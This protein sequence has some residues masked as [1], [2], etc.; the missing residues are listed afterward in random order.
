MYKRQGDALEELRDDS[1][2][3]AARTIEQ[4]V[5]DPRQ[6]GGEMLIGFFFEDRKRRAQRKAKVGARVTVGN[7]EHVNVIQKILLADN[8]MDTGYQR[9]GERP[10]VEMAC[11]VIR[12][13]RAL[14]ARQQERPPLV[15]QHDALGRDLSDERTLFES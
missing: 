11:G 4:G 5:R 8:A 7:R 6:Q 10:A 14:F 9:L 15:L 1:P 13:T 3:V 2:G 12:Q